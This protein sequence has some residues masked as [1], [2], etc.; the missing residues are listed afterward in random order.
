MPSYAGRVALI[1]AFGLALTAA[2]A[3]LVITDR[4]VR[5]R[6]KQPRRMASA[7]CD[8]AQS[9]RREIA[10]AWDLLHPSTLHSS[11]NALAAAFP[12]PLAV[13]IYW[14]QRPFPKLV[15]A[16]IA[17]VRR[18]A[19]ASR[20]HL[21]VHVVTQATLHEYIDTKLHTCLNTPDARKAT[22]SDFIRLLLL[23]QYGGIYFDATVVVSDFD[24]LLNQ[25]QSNVFYAFYN[26]RNM[27][28][29]DDV[30]VV[31][32]SF[33]MA[34]PAHP[35]IGAWIDELMRLTTHCSAKK[36]L[37]VKALT[38]TQRHMHPEY[39]F[40]YH[41][42]T[43]VFLAHPLP[44]FHD[45]VLLSSERF[46]YLFFHF[47]HAR[48]LIEPASRATVTPTFT[49]LCGWERTFVERQWQDIRPGSFIHLMLNAKEGVQQ[50]A[51]IHSRPLSPGRNI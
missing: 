23:K 28:V 8:D 27:T 46:R 45:V 15:A 24:W 20:H 38:N 33:L 13:W 17:K 42:L 3:G 32:N 14:D 49:K 5:R 18:A 10:S 6:P 40:A 12:E 7:R 21:Q 39:H 44:S 29:G 48:A 22:Q 30:P 11:V 37:N 19:A 47:N 1:A 26:R 9:S 16:C 50:I 25:A 36:P 41:A 2:I 34:P 43:N 4:V 51:Q 31:E 35:L